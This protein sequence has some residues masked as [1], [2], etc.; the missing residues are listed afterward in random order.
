MTSE[1]F[2]PAKIN[3]TLH[4]TGQ[5]A[6]G[7]HLLDSLVV[8]ADVGDLLTITPASTLSLKVTGTFAKGVPE[9]ASNLVW[10]AA[11]L[12]GLTAHISLKK[13]LPHGAGIGGGSSDAGAV[14]RHCDHA[15]SA[16]RLGADVPAC[17]TPHAQRMRGIG[18]QLDLLSGLPVLHAVLVNPNVHLPTSDVFRGLPGKQNPPMPAT[19]P[20][21]SNAHSFTKWLSTMRNDLETAAIAIAPQVSDVLA[22]IRA[23]PDVALARMSGSGATC[24]GL[25]DTEKQAHSAARMLGMQNPDWW[26]RSTQLS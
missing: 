14:L 18:D 11:E 23:T 19:L 4:V 13:N 1:V 22:K 9:D 5:R 17:L 15:K 21:H 10:Q 24:F 8:F 3:L 12:A 6:D 2:A 25:Y 20:P 26:V 7:Y 16:A